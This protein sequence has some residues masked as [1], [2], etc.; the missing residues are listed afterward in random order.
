MDKLVVEE[1]S[2]FQIPHT[3]EVKISSLIMER[4]ESD[5]NNMSM[6]LLVV[7][8]YELMIEAGFTPIN[9]PPINSD[10]DKKAASQYIST[11]NMQC[12]RNL[13]QNWKQNQIYVMSF[14]L[15]PFNEKY[16]CRLIAVPCGDSLIANAI[17]D[18]YVGEKLIKDRCICFKILDYVINPNSSKHA[19][20]FVN[21]KDLSYKF[22]DGI[23]SPI[24]CEILT[25]EG[26]VN[27]S[28]LG[29]PDEIKLKI[30]G[31]LPVKD[32]KNI[33]KS[34][35]R[36]FFLS[37]DQSLWRYLLKRDFN[38]VPN[39][40]YKMVVKNIY[41]ERYREHLYSIRMNQR[42]NAMTLTT[43]DGLFAHNMQ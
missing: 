8:I 32:I 21:L 6:D 24:R 29:L 43:G 42:F 34:C 36:M 40:N 5:S 15:L 35:R 20:K 4:N 31:N 19:E 10:K 9:A 2:S 12:Y 38:Y 41:I 39:D 27:P 16:K 25:N 23:T 14:V 26:A 1:S 37:K 3:L 18:T 17:V 11:Q 30:L 13:P 33:S 28:L 7:V 22:K